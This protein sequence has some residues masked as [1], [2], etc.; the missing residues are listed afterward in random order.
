MHKNP[1]FKCLLIPPFR[2]NLLHGYLRNLKNTWK[3]DKK[4]N[5]PQVRTAY[6]E[7]RLL[8][9]SPSQ[10]LSGTEGNG[11]SAGKLTSRGLGKTDR[12]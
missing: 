3:K 9:C 4:K 2:L 10:C 8:G 12:S 6:P 7:H 1:L 5:L 11:C